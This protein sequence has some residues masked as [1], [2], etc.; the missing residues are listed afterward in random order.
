MNTMMEQCDAGPAMLSRYPT[1]R[2]KSEDRS[3]ILVC[4][5]T[6]STPNKHGRIV[7]LLSPPL[8]DQSMSVHMTQLSVMVCYQ[9]YATSITGLHTYYTATPIHQSTWIIQW[10]S[11]FRD[12]AKAKALGIR[13]R[14]R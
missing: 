3:T 8:L 7:G 14:A 11:R 10:Y 5:D 9:Q 13:I 4:S 12:I 6:L 1:L 2:P